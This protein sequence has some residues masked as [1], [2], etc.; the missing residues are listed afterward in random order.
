MNR[1]KKP[2]AFDKSAALL[3]MAREHGCPVFFLAHEA[4][5]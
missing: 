2:A 3:E 5:R 1:M 4:K